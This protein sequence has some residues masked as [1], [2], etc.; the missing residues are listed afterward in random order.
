MSSDMVE[1]PSHY[2][3]GNGYETIDVIK[4]AIGEKG[5]A[6]YCQGNV[7][8]YAIRARFKENP[9]QDMAKAAVYAN[10]AAEAY[11]RIEDGTE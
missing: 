10:W 8:K 9:A 3:H 6:A 7:L 11:E 5:F 2:L 1:R 4:D